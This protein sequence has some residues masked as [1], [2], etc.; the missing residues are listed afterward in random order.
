MPTLKQLKQELRLRI[1]EPTEGSWTSAT[2]YQ[3]NTAVIESLDELKLAIEA[4]EEKVTE[5]LIQEEKPL[6]IGGA[7]LPVEAR[8]Y[9]YPLPTDFL[10]MVMLQHK[11]QGIFYTLKPA[12]VS[13]L[14]NDFDPND[15]NTILA[16]YDIQGMTAKILAEGVAT[17]G[18]HTV[19]NDTN[20]NSFGSPTDDVDLV[21]NLR[22]DSIATITA[23]DA[24]SVTFGAGLQG[25]GSNTFR[26]GDRYQIESAEETQ[27]ILWVW[28]PLNEGNVETLASDTGA[29]TTTLTI[30]SATS[31]TRS[32]TTTEPTVL[33]SVTLSIATVS[34]EL[35]P[36]R[37]EIQQTA[38]GAL[39]S[40]N[41]ESVAAVDVP[42]VGNNEAFFEYGIELAAG[43]YF[44]EA[45]TIEDASYAWNSSASGGKFIIK[46]YTGEEEMIMQYARYPRKYSSGVT[47]D[48]EMS[49]VPLFAKEAV[50]LWSEHLLYRKLRGLRHPDTAEARQLYEFELPKILQRLNL[51]NKTEFSSVRNVFPLRIGGGRFH[52]IGLNFPV[53]AP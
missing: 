51:Q 18:S 39:A 43:T 36:I 10:S 44:I 16:F 52:T 27:Q 2:D 6:L 37:I 21:R 12:R 8:I 26:A 41:P 25:G 40:G 4:A 32:F 15:T 23:S 9:Q 14:F 53:N 50:L 47:G 5:D 7:K 20:G 30:D 49:E 33:Y 31:P 28:P 17:G 13:L 1:G 11:S 19:L 22:D 46:G 48:G 29:T 24:T 38:G 34:T 42:I 45:S 3:T 35:Q